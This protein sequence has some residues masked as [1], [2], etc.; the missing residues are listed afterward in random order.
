MPGVALRGFLSGGGASALYSVTGVFAALRSSGG[1]FEK[2]SG[3]MI[4]AIRYMLHLYIDMTLYLYY[5][6]HIYIYIHIYVHMGHSGAPP[7]SSESEV[8][9]KAGFLAA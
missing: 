8:S 4:S 9:E 5:M 6:I 2:R 3:D 1:L 7:P